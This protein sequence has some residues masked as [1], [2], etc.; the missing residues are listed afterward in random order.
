MLCCVTGPTAAGKSALVQALCPLLP[1]E[2]LIINGDSQQIYT[3]FPHLTDQPSAHP[4]HRLY[5]HISAAN[6]E[7]YS[8]H[9][10]CQQVLACL[11]TVPPTTFVWIVGGTGFYFQTLYRGLSPVPAL[12]LRDKHIFLDTH[13][14]TQTPALH[15]LLHTQD[16]VSAQ[17]LAPQDRHRI[18]HA[19]W[20][21]HATGT[22]LSTWHTLP[23]HPYLH[24]PFT[25]LHVDPKDSLRE[26]IAHR[27]HRTKHA[28]YDEVI[29]YHAQHPTTA[30]AQRILGFTLWSQV[31]T[32]HLSFDAATEQLFFRTC[33]YAKRQRTWFRSHPLPHTLHVNRDTNPQDILPHILPAD[34]C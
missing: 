8:V 5:G 9:Q 2:S 31:H 22:P 17:R 19:L 23:R 18:L 13:K 11:D 25:T 3:E 10:W 12:H 28:M 34:A 32:R 1:Y 30:S 24:R 20:I 15:A 27:I 14:E 4:H 29:Q 7:Q 26:S 16:A 33:Q 6:D 21:Y